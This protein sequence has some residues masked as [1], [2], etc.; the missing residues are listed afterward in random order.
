V[1]VL[2]VVKMYSWGLLLFPVRRR[3]VSHTASITQM[4]NTQQCEDADNVIAKFIFSNDI[5]FHVT[6]SPYYKE[7]FRNIAPACT[8][9][10]SSREHKMRTFLLDKP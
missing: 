2:V 1:G 3:S 8:S 7:M 9:Y 4:Y 6:H 5:H 10:V